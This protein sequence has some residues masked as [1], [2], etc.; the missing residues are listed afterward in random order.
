[1]LGLPNTD[2]QRIASSQVSANTWVQNN[3]KNYGNVNFKYIAVGNEVQPSDPSTQYLVPAMQNIQTAITN[4]GL[5]NQ[6]KYP[7]QWT[8]A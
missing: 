8:L 2:L 7:L 4:A 3:V 5:G 1:M 6:S